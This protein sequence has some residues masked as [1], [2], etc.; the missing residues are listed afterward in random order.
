M[1]RSRIIGLV[2]AVVAALLAVYAVY[3][4]SQ[5]P[6]H[7]KDTLPSVVVSVL[8]VAALVYGLLVPWAAKRSP[9]KAGLIVSI[10]GFLSMAAF[11]SGLPIVLGSAGAVLGLDAQERVGG[12]SGK[13]TAAMIVGAVAAALCI[14]VTVVGNLIH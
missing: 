8:V 5:A 7:Q 4:D 1:T 9:G 10:I 11:W 12:K 14:G 2:A 6:Q 3:G 13:A